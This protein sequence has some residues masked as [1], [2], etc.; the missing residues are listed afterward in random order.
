[1]N[2]RTDD[3]FMAESERAVALESERFSSYDLERQTLDDFS[4]FRLEVSLLLRI[5]I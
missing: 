1:M 2:M 5:T 3:I 4:Y